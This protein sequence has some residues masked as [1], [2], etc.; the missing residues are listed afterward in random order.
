MNKFYNEIKEFL[1]NP[2]DNMENFFNSRAITWIDWREYDEDIISYFNGLLPQGDIVDVE[3]KE[4]KLGRGIDIILKK[5]NKTLTI[6][7]EE[8]ETD[9]DI[10]IKTLDEFISPKY[11]IRLFSESLGDDTL[12]FTVLNSDEWK[13]LENEFGKEKLEFFFTPV[14]QFKGIFNMSMKEVK[15]IYTER[16]VLRDKIFKNN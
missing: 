16:E 9:R 15:K 5:D 3:T 8:D 4:I 10:T 12:A 13:D 2:V 14:S 1:E 6:P 11:Q 7:Y